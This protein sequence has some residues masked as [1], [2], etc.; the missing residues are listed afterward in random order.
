[1]DDEPDVTHWICNFCGFNAL[2]NEK[3]ECI[4]NDCGAK[5]KTKLKDP[6]KEF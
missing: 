5:A 6:S 4:C 1:M 3:D 2:E